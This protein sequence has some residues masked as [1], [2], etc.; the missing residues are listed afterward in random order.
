MP[1][2]RL[3]QLLLPAAAGSRGRTSFLD[4]R[5]ELVEQ[6]G[7]I[8]SYVQAP[9]EGVWTS[10]D[11]DRDVDR[12]IMVEVVVTTFD[13]AWWRRYAATLATRFAERA[14]HIRT[15]EIDVLDPDAL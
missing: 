6:F 10:P 11:G 7:G 5:A 14:I 12:M 13:R 2:A 4:T 15:L 8:T 9:A 1:R 3:V